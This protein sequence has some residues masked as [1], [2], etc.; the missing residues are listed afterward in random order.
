MMIVEIL[1]LGREKRADDEFRDRLD[2]HEN[3]PLARV[4]G[5][6]AAVHGMQ[7]R[8]DRRLIMGKLLIVRQVPS[9]MP[10]RDADERGADDCQHHATN[11]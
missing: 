5:E 3:P 11:K 8:R 1:V 4:F 2:R 9:E 10:D 7:S 6:K